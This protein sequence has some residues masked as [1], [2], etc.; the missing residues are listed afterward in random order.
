MMR[1]AYGR[2]RGGAGVRLWPGVV[3]AWVVAWGAFPVCGA[4]GKSGAAPGAEIFEA[5]T[6]VDFRLRL[7][8]TNLAA[9]REE[10]R[11]Y[12]PA[13]VI[14]NG[15]AYT[16]VGVKLKGA[17]G[18]FRGIDDQPALT[19]H[20]SKWVDKRRVFGLRR[21]HLNNS[22]QDPSY[23]NEYI[24]SDL[25]RAAGVPTPRV[26]WATVGINERTLGLYVLKEAF[27][28]EFLKLFFGESDG[29]LYDGGFLQDVNQKLE[30]DSGDGPDGHSDLDALYAATQIEDRPRR[31]ERLGQVLDIDRFV[32]YAALEVMLADWDGYP[33]NRNNYRVYFRKRDGRAVFLPHGMDQLF[34]R[35]SMELDS[36]WTGAVASGLFDTPEGQALYQT[37]CREVFTNVFRLERMTNAIARAVAALK[38]AQPDIA[39]RAADLESQITRRVRN[40]R[41]DELLKPPS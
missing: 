37:R 16:N 35:S 40:L 15:Q 28:K 21:L 27:E 4:G 23:L 1:L 25:F 10:P 26:A 2:C 41:R 8:S 38:P 12:T 13:T 14:V 6:V 30:R 24:A 11:E 39:D 17:A 36:G 7:E 9:L 33:L 5:P 19:L 34:E 3:L 29:N 32:T 22:V 18:S 20:F 31:W